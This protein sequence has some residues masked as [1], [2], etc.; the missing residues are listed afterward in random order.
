MSLI[1]QVS[2]NS[3]VCPDRTSNRVHSLHSW[4][5]SD[6]AMNNTNYYSFYSPV[7]IS[8]GNFIPSYLYLHSG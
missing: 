3:L 5:L 1:S 2:E 7:H 6:S 8:E 4:P